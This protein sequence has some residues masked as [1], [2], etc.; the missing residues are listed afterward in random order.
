MTNFLVISLP[1]ALTFTFD[2]VLGPL[3]VIWHGN[4]N[5]IFAI[6]KAKE[7][8]DDLAAQCLETGGNAF[9]SVSGV[10]HH[11]LLGLGAGFAD[12]HEVTHIG[13]GL[14]GKDL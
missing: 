5:V 11:K 10:V 7:V 3:P 13:I 6:P 14:N 8:I 9:L 2:D 4:D 1:L 12:K